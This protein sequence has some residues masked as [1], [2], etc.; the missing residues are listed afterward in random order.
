MFFSL[1]SD[2][3]KQ[4]IKNKP[5]QPIIKINETYRRLKQVVIAPWNWD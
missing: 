3:I 4:S 5:I 1:V 2:V